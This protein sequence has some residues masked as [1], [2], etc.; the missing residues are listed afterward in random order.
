MGPRSPEGKAAKAF[1]NGIDKMD[2]NEEAVAYMLYNSSRVM[3]ARLY[4]IIMYLINMWAEDYDRGDFTNDDMNACVNA[5][6]IRDA[7]ETYKVY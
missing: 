6:R 5:A 1:L 2:I 4:R 3:H 7:M